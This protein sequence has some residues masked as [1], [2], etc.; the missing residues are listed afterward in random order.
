MFGAIR[1]FQRV[2]AETDTNGI[3]LPITRYLF[4]NGCTPPNAKR[5][6]HRR[7]DICPGPSG[8]TD[9]RI[10][11]PLP[12]KTREN[13]VRGG[14]CGWCGWWVGS[15]RRPIGRLARRMRGVRGGCLV[16]H[17]VP[18]DIVRKVVIGADQATSPGFTSA[19]AAC[20]TVK[21]TISS[22]RTV[23]KI[24]WVIRRPVPNKRC[25]SS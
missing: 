16:L 17:L 15:A 24:R 4:G 18:R 22:L 12:L 1:T 7:R 21:T 23:N 10:K 5:W 8:A 6:Q 14:R 11:L 20:R 25:R 2:L 19:W 3:V 9:L 13:L